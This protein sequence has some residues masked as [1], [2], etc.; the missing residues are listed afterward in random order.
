VEE[1]EDVLARNLKKGFLLEDQMTRGPLTLYRI[2]PWDN[3]LGLPM[4]YGPGWHQAEDWGRWILEESA[5]LEMIE[6]RFPALLVI[7]A[8]SWQDDQPQTCRVMIGGRQA[9][10]FIVDTEPWKWEEFTISLEGFEDGPQV[11]T[12]E[13]DT[14]LQDR[15]GKTRRALPVAGLR[16]LPA[17]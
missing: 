6:A 5:S 8:A 4:H 1:V 3:K 10:S 13:F 17:D 16:F 7:K 14:L 15:G 2:V 12:L 9:G 11:I